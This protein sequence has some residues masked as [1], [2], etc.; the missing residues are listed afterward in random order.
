MATTMK[1]AQMFQRA[2]TQVRRGPQNPNRQR[3][4]SRVGM[5]PRMM[6]AARAFLGTLK[7]PD[8][9]TG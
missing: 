9:G 2:S 8:K 1:R 3:Q 5:A 6:A 4:P 7:G